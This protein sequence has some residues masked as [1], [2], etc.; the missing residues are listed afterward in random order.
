MA[1]CGA[2]H[3]QLEGVAC[4]I[5]QERGT[6]SPHTD[7]EHPPWPDP[8]IEERRKLLKGNR[9]VKKGATARL[10]KKVTDSRK[11]NLE[12]EREA[13]AAA[14]PNV[15]AD[16]AET[17]QEAAD[18]YEPKRG[19]ARARVLDYLRARTGEWVD[20]PE[21]T[22]PSVGG[23][24]GT[25]RLRE[26]REVGWPIE[27]RPKPDTTNTWQHRLLAEGSPE[28]ASTGSVAPSDCGTGVSQTPPS[29]EG[30]TSISGEVE[31][32]GPPGVEVPYV[33]R[34]GQ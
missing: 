30:D 27:T 31:Q 3:P 1:I 6:H 11:Q 18:R 17:A 4:L 15:R 26:L 21:L 16:D 25:R 9:K 28:T 10:H 8:E 22:D 29:V 7:W 2:P 32:N 14:L 24:G 34:F 19:T 20:A 13:A 33:G 12:A 5:K 23:F